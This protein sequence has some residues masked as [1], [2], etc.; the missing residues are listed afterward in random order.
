MQFVVVAAFLSIVAAASTARAEPLFQTTIEV[1]NAPLRSG[2]GQSFYITGYVPEQTQIDVYD[3]QDDGW[4]AIRPP[5][6]SFSWVPARLLEITEDPRVAKVIDEGVVSWIGTSLGTARN[7]H[8]QV[9]LNR[10]ETVRIIDQAER[11]DASDASRKINWY[12]IQPPAGEFRWIHRRH[13]QTPEISNNQQE[14]DALSNEPAIIPH[15]LN[16]GNSVK[17]AN[18]EESAPVSEEQPIR[19]KSPNNWVPKS[20]KKE[21]VAIRDE[22]EKTVTDDATQK[23]RNADIRSLEIELSLMAAEPPTRWNL[24]PLRERLTELIDSGESALERGRARLLLEE[25]SR[26]ES[27]QSRHARLNNPQTNDNTLPNDS[28]VDQ[29]SV[30]PNLITPTENDDLYDGSGWLLPVHSSTRLTPPFALLDDDGNILHFISPAPGMNLRRYVK[31]RVGVIGR[32]GTDT[33]LNAP[34]LT[35]ERIIDLQRHKR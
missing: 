16:N 24:S 7:Y 3:E 25:I 34:Y 23:S 5:V 4:L 17:L 31:K 8:W 22:K 26:F 15:P 14:S 18:Q 19:E 29:S 28:I 6:G 20:Q 10:G 33:R 27:L 13:I 9:R 2:P 32:E 21:R 11:E 30:A 1:E 35:A 12:K